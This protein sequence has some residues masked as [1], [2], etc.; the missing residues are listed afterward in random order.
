MCDSD[1]TFRDTHI[2]RLALQGL[3]CCRAALASAQ[4]TLSAK[5]VPQ[6]LPTCRVARV[7][8]GLMHMRGFTRGIYALQDRAD[9][10]ASDIHSIL[11]LLL[12]GW[13]LDDFTVSR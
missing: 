7:C 4:C 11:G 3:S 1:F 6:T 2:N 8:K 10:P 9:R 12:L 5:G 13:W